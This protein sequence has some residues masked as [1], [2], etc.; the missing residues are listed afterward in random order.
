MRTVRTKLDCGAPM[1]SKAS[2]WCSRIRCASRSLREDGVE[3]LERSIRSAPAAA[4]TIARLR[5]DEP[6]LAKRHQRAV[7]VGPKGQGD[8][9]L[10]IA[11][12]RKPREHESRRAQHF[13]ILTGDLDVPAVGHVHRNVIA[14]ADARLD[15]RDLATRPPGRQPLT[16]LLA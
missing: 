7:R 15:A 3:F 6:F 10:L 5:I 12:M 14:A 13:T 4:V 9:G 16:P 8:Q 2:A 11:V 1:I